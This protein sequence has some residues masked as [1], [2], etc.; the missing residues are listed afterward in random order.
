MKFQRKASD[1]WDAVDEVGKTLGSVLV[2]GG[3]SC[4]HPVQNC[5]PMIVEELREIAEF[6]ESLTE[7]P[8]HA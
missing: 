6:A 7:R 2:E 1:K 3:V 8:A 5:G 4:F